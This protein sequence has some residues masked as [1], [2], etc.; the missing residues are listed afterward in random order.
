MPEDIARCRD[1]GWT[2]D[3]TEMNTQEQRNELGIVMEVIE[4]CPKCD[5]HNVGLVQTRES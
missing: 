2:G 5:S 4:I 1:C 3:E